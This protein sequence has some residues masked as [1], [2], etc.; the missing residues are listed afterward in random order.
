MASPPIPPSAAD[1]AIRFALTAKRLR[2]RDLEQLVM[3]GGLVGAISG[4]VHALQRERG[5]S[6]VYL[7]SGGIDF[8]DRL[9]LAVQES[10]SGESSVRILFDGL[11][12]KADSATF[13]PRL[14]SRI[15]YVLHSLSGLRD[16]RAAIAARKTTPEEATKAFSEVVAGLL[17]VAFEAS[18]TG[19]D[20]VISRALVAM[21]NFMQGKEFA[22]QERAT[23]AAG[24]SAGC[25]SQAQHARLLKLIDAQARSFEIF[26]QF[27]DPALAALLAQALAGPEMAE[28]ERMRRIAC[29]GGVTG[30]LAGVDSRRWFDAAT[31]RMDAMYRVEQRIDTDLQTLCALKMAE[32]QADLDE[33]RQS[34]CGPPPAEPEPPQ[35]AFVIGEVDP[36][37]I[38]DATRTG[39]EVYSVDGISPKLGRSLLDLVQSQFRHM[40]Q[41]SAELETAR[42]AID[43][44]KIVERAKGLLMTHRG[45]T[46]QQ[47]YD[48][49]RKTAMS[50]NR[51]MKEVAEA[52]IAMADILSP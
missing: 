10:D 3:V 38:A 22:G 49:L 17:A 14:Y 9:P 42:L 52:I 33:H 7:G 18:D 51:R 40:Q 30:Q 39:V 37:L 11:E 36:G 43:E 4:L 44:R 25:F 23:A 2:L 24:F 32:A 15:A 41:M 50:Q 26:V 20:P 45:L 48:L 13:A 12:R 1:P 16:L 46:E 8:A 29:V 5:T 21:F 34:L 35:S 27:A 19:A 31:A 47:A 6:N 28:F